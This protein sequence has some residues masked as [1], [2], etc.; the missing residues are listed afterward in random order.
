MKLRKI[1][2]ELFHSTSRYDVHLV[3]YPSDLLITK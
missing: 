3:D 2:R 1:K